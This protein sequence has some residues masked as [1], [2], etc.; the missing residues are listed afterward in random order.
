M[1]FNE[2]IKR[3]KQAKKH[4]KE[5]ATNIHIYCGTAYQITSD[6]CICGKLDKSH[7]ISIL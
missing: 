5:T 7:D 1:K 4:E 6:G 2:F 3:R